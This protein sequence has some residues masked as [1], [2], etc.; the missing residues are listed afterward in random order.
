MCALITVSGGLNVDEQMPNVGASS[1]KLAPFFSPEMTSSPSGP[2]PSWNVGVLD[3]G[4]NEF[5]TFP[6]F[7]TN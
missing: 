2:A 7:L 5:P 6:P 4:E 3:G 1:Q